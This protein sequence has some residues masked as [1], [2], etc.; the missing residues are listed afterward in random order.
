MATE[1][2]KRLAEGTRQKIANL[3][4]VCA[5]V[6]EETASRAPAGRWSPKEILSH[7]LGP[8]GAGHL[9]LLQEFLEEDTPLLAVEAENPFYSAGRQRA[10]FRELLAEV[11]GVYGRIAAF[12]EGLSPEQLGRKAHVPALKDS[13]LGEY[14]TL[15]SWI[16]GFLDYH[17]QFHTN[18]LREILGEL[19]VRQGGGL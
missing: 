14:P 4:E 12:A 19:G 8:E 3:K 6:D 13:P 16:G 2:G 7:L 11:E 10:T 1:T 15:E 17:L 5:G 18:H 9:A